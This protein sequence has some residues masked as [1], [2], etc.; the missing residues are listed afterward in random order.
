MQAAG[1]RV[2]LSAKLAACVQRRHHGFDRRNLGCSVDIH[3]DATAVVLNPHRAILPDVNAYAGGEVG[4]EL[5]Y[6][7]VHDL[8]YQV[9]EASLVDA[10]D[11]HAGAPAY[12]FHA[13]QHLYVIS[14]VII[15]AISVA[16]CRHVSLLRSA[17][18]MTCSA[19]GG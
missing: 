3:G 9:V 8:V 7:V 18:L 6:T 4:H 15:F 13:L 2:S 1:H 14:G 19:A 11:V 12:G 10:A 5:V 16:A 17:V